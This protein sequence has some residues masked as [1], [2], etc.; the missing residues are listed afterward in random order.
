LDARGEKKEVKETFAA[1]A[2]SIHGMISFH[3]LLLFKEVIN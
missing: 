2:L 3:L 1:A